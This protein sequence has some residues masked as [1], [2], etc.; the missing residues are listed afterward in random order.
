LLV[1][2]TEQTENIYIISTNR[3]EFLMEADCY[4]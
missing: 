1:I 2:S 4:L 3:L